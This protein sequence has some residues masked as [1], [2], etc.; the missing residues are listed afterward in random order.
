MWRAWE[1][2]GIAAKLGPYIGSGMTLR[3]VATELECSHVAV[4]KALR[5][6][7]VTL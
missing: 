3:D 7:G 5:K 4:W 2:K 6:M 1:K